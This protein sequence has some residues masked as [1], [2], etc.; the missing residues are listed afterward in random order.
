VEEHYLPHDGI[1]S[2]GDSGFSIIRSSSIFYT[3]P[4]QTHFFNCP[5]S[6]L[7]LAVLYR[8]LMRGNV[9]S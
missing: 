6:A 9:D 2:L 7:A 1:R 5:K 3:Q 4:V 8:L